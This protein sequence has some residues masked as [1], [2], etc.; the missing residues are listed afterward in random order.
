MNL[1]LGVKEKEKG[2]GWFQGLG[3]GRLDGWTAIVFDGE[4]YRGAGLL[5]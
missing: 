1:M 2:Q 4:N 3:P 5:W